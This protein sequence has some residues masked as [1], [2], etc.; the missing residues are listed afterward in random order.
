MSFRP[1]AAAA[2]AA[3]TVLSAVSPA[4]AQEAVTKTAQVS[5]ADLNLSSPAGVERLHNRVR[6]AARSV[7]GTNAP[8]DIDQR[9]A[10]NQCQKAAIEGA[11][12]QMDRLIAAA[13]TPERYAMADAGR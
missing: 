8:Q 12:P 6:S 10:Y 1:F 13:Q 9:I 3:V 7:C 4:L 11:K 5:V 2:L